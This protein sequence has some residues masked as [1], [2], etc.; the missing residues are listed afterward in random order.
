MGRTTPGGA[1]RAPARKLRLILI[2]ALVAGALSTLE[3]AVASASGSATLYAYPNGTQTSPT[4]CP[5]TTASSSECS[6]AGAIALAESST[7]T[8]DNV[9]IVLAAGGYANASNFSIADS[10]AGSLTLDGSAGAV[11]CGPLA[12]A[13]E[14]ACSGLTSTASTTASLVTLGTSSTPVT[15]SDLTITGGESSG[16][17]GAGISCNE[18]TESVTLIGST[19]SDNSASGDGGGI[20]C[21][22]PLTITSS[23]V[24]SN[25]AT[26]TAAYGGGVFAPTLTVTDSV[27]SDNTVTPSGTGGYTF[28][29]GI[30]SLPLSRTRWS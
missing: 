2:G 1:S 4:S 30:A 3:S 19:V 16:E 24:V 21:A 27:I 28:G 6:L 22:G 5:S 8:G 26:G 25:T 14:T 13:A 15:F 23:S 12:P 9:T 18:A 10:N 7:Y 20:D 29:G 17:G 11:L